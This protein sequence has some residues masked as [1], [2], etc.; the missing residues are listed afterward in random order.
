MIDK[1]DEIISDLVVEKYDLQKAYNYYDGKRDPEQFKYLEENYGIGS[2]TSVT[3]TPLLKKHFDAL[4]GE[5]LNVPIIPKVYCKDHDTISNINREKQLKITGEIVKF[6]KDHLSNSLL[7]FI[8]GKDITDKSIKRQLDQIIQDVDESFT[9]QYEIA[10]QNIIEYFLQSRDM[11]VVTKVTTLL[12]DILITGYSFFQAHPSSSN[13]NVCLEVL[14]PRNTF[15]ETNPNSPYVKNSRKCVIRRW[16]DKDDIL[17]RYGKEMKREDIKQFKDRW[18]EDIASSRYRR[19]YGDSCIAVD[20]SY[21]EDD[22]LPGHPSD[23]NF[24]RQLVPVYEVEWIQADDDFVLQRYT[25]VRIGE[26]FYILRGIDQNVIRTHDNPNDCTISVNGVYFLNR[27]SRPYSLMLKC[28][29][30]QDEYDLLIYYKNNLIG[31]SGT[32]G[33]IIDVSLI[34]ASLG[35]KWPERIQK[36]IAY[37]KAGLQLIDTT[38]EGRNDNGNAPMNTIFNGFDDTLKAQ[39]I[40]AIEV[41]IQSL[42]NTVSSISGVF[43]ERLNGIQ[44]RDA[45]TNIQQGVNN[46]FI[47]TKHLYQHMDLVVCEL[48]LDCI[49]QAKIVYKN[50]LTGTIVMGKYQKIFTALPEHFTVTDYDIQITSSTEVMQDIQTIKQ[51]VPELIKSQLLPAD[52]LIEV[53]TSKSLTDLKYKVK[54][55]MKFQKEENDQIKQL[56]QKLEETTQQAQQLQKQLEQ[57]QKKLEQMDQQKM[58]LEQQKMQLEY[59][60]EM[61]KANTDKTYKE[62][63]VDIE[64]KRTQIEIAQIHDGNPYNDTVK[65]LM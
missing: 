30:L 55:A 31:N 32:S 19:V 43:R 50:G 57:A 49:N 18:D 33:S 13:T 3:F 23:L 2:P 26:E 65:R 42:E 35:V 25:T 41:A 60:V 24:R 29:H 62:Q 40:Q 52:I 61:L 5:Y 38:Q 27:T 37:K 15:I 63:M 51:I 21:D 1:T 59:K 56:N 64:Q 47:I 12:R 8:D 36:W 16:L 11:D 28:M 14:D 45:V 17:A 54:K 10:A 20:E 7:S 44:Q 46:S 34:P 39:A 58:Q 22:P 9:S 6:L 53:L 48:L 4:V